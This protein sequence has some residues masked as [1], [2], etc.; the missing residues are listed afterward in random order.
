ML[1]KMEKLEIHEN[2]LFFLNTE[3][4]RVTGDREGS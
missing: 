1:L 4:N 2:L 3:G